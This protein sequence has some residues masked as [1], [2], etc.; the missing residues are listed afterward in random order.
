MPLAAVITM[1]AIQTADA[2]TSA[3]LFAVAA[4]L[5]TFGVAPG[6]AACLDI[7]GEHTGVV[8]GAMNMCGN[9][10]GAALPLAMGLCLKWW[11][12]WNISLT[13][14]AIFY[15]IAALCWLGVDAERPIRD[16]GE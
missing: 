6:W 10:G 3:Y 9:L 16:S 4:G 1:V 13:S 5:A 12:S 14:V 11:G 8:T 7:G 15:F 2:K